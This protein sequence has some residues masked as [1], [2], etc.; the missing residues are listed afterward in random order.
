MNLTLPE[1]NITQLNGL[2]H[3]C[4]GF[5]FCLEVLI[6]LVMILSVFIYIQGGS[7]MTGTI[8]V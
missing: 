2:G 7:N 3:T 5:E 8:C 4:L 6:C 1:Y